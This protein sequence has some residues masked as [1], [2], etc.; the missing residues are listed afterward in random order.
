[1]KFAS[2]GERAERERKRKQRCHFWRIHR[3][4][5]RAA[6]IQSPSLF[7]RFFDLSLNSCSLS[8][9][10]LI[11]DFHPDRQ[12]LRS[13]EVIILCLVTS[14]HLFAIIAPLGCK[15]T[16]LFINYLNLRVKGSFCCFGLSQCAKFTLFLFL[17]QH[18]CQNVSISMLFFLLISTGP[19]IASRED[20][21]LFHGEYNILVPCSIDSKILV[22][23]SRQYIIP[24]KNCFFI[25]YFFLNYFYF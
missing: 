3:I 19:E 23:S 1:M 13:F 17:F 4:S 14:H 2:S 12:I 20:H 6:S 5:F 18:F 16:I 10:S 15:S 22:P 7:P 11:T 24:Y 25:G 8:L 21:I 9:S